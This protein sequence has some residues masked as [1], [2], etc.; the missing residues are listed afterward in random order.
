MPF[1]PLIMLKSKVGELEAL[2]RL[3]P[4]GAARPVIAVELLNSIAAEGRGQLL[5]ALVKAAVRLA[6]A[7]QPLWIDAHLLSRTNSLAQQ[8]GGPLQ[9]L[10]NRIEGALHDEFGLL[11]PD[12]PALIPVVL[13]SASDDELKAVSLLQEHRQRDVAVRIRGLDLPLRELDDRLRRIAHRT[14]VESGH[15]HVV[16]DL[17]FI[18]AVR[19]ADVERASRLV[20]V[21]VDRLGPGSAA[22]LAGSIPAARSG[23]VTTTRD[24]PEVPLWREV[25]GRAEGAEVHYGDYGVVHPVSSDNADPGPRSIH[26]YLYYTVPGC[27]LT[28]RRRLA[29]E[30]GKTVQGAAAEAFSEIAEELTRRPEFAGKNYSWGD[31]ELARCRRGGGSAAGSVSRWVA[32]ATSHHIEHLARR[33]SPDL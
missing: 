18:E 11:A 16:L 6:V 21:V 24:R 31:H 19:T 30:D 7:E 27:T 22:L 26:P 17:G 10:E 33:T 32:I 14:R 13:D 23:F 29:R 4:A 12:V 8:P 1:T 3:S 20:E 9:F 25:A 15:L 28:L 2:R 5:P